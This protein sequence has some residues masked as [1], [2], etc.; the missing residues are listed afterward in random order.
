MFSIYINVSFNFVFQFLF[1]I[2]M[3][4]LFSGGKEIEEYILFGRY[5]FDCEI[6]VILYTTSLSVAKEYT[7][8][9][10]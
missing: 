3:V 9:V 5:F 7:I 8:F 4:E 6:F 1:C 2:K 10:Y